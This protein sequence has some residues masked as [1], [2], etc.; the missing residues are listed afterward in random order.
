MLLGPMFLDQMLLAWRFLVLSLASPSSG[1]S[2]ASSREDHP[3]VHSSGA[4]L[5]SA[6]GLDADRVSHALNDIA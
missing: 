1:S 2:L 6:A 3:A 5:A 4:S